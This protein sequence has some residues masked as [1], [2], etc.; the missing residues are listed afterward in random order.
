MNGIEIFDNVLSEKDCQFII[1]NFEGDSRKEIGSCGN[2]NNINPSIKL[3]TDIGC[4][5]SNPS[6]V[7]Y[8]DIILPNLGKCVKELE[9][10]YEI[11]QTIYYWGINNDYNLQRYRDGEGY[12]KLHC[13]HGQNC[14]YRI[15]AWMIYLN[16]ASCGTEFPYQGTTIDAKMGR[17]VIWSS[18]WIYAH[19][20]VTPNIGEKYIATGWISFRV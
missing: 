7:L 5:F 14:P 20:G 6:F 10:K 17:C 12:F 4:D 3:S 11:L 2:P 13:E 19:R 9:G 18:S 16:D 8:N 15:A 1:D